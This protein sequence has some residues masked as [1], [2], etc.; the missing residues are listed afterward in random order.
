MGQ[1][2]AARGLG[3]AYGGQS[4]QEKLAGG[5]T[6]MIFGSGIVMV[7][8]ILSAQY[9]SWSLPVAVLLVVPF[10]CWARCS[11]HGARHPE[12]PLFHHRPR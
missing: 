4:L 6:A 5:S 10:G 9:E 3:Y 1:E 2:F 8:L 7:F 11:Q 12:R